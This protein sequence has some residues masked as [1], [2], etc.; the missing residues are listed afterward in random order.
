[1]KMTQN[2][3]SPSPHSSLKITKSFLENPTR[4]QL[5]T[6]SRA[7][8]EISLKF[9]FFVFNFVEILI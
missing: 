7:H 1:M 3:I 9:F 4:Q 6:I 2:S 5:P 8:P